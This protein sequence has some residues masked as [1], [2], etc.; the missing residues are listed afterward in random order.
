MSNFIRKDTM[1]RSAAILR[2][3]CQAASVRSP[4]EASPEQCLYFGVPWRWFSCAELEHTEKLGTYPVRIE[5]SSTMHF[6]VHSK[7]CWLVTAKHHY[8][9]SLGFSGVSSLRRMSS[10]YTR[11]KPDGLESAVSKVSSTGSS[12][13]DNTDGGGNTWIDMSEDAHRS[14]VDASTAAGNNIK[15]PN[16]AITLRFQELFGNHT[17]LEK[18]IVPL[19]GTLIGT[20]MAWFVMPIVLRK[21]H[22]YASDGPLRTLWGDS[23]KKHVSY[24]TSLWSAL[25]DPAKYM[26]T[27]MAFSQILSSTGM[28]WGIAVSLVW[29]LHR[30]KTNFIGHAMAKQAATRTDRERLSAFDKMSSLG[31][32]AL[33]V[34]ALAEACGVLV[35]SILTVGGVGGVATAFAT[36]DILGNM[37]SGFSLQFSRPFSVGD[38]IKAGSIEGQVVEIGLTST[39]LIN[40]EKLPVV[41][42]NSL[43]SS[44]GPVACY[45]SVAKLPIRIEDIEKVP[46]ITEEIKVMLTS[47]SKIDAAYCYLSRLEISSGELTIGCNIKSTKTDEWSST[48]QDILLKAASIIKRHQLWTPV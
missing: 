6:T 22:K 40:T 46:A 7:N 47:N 32:I 18:V 41:V 21:L 26:I 2:W 37:L 28:E 12:K 13:V 3:S 38:Y 45:A 15:R 10:S 34:I 43:F 29:F 24:E 44:Q 31:L 36:R 42:P 48:E 35:Q 27:F 11:T 30:W 25:E 39:S 17:D 19:G 14:A 23:T 20:T 4:R 33:G 5:K 1:F 9:Q 16:D 8:N